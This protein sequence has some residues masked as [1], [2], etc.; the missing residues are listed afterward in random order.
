MRQVVLGVLSTPISPED[1]ISVGSTAKF[2]QAG[3]L[4]LAG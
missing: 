3:T 2:T 4:V 1:A